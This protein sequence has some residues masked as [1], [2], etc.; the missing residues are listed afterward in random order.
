MKLKYLFLHN[1]ARISV[2]GYALFILV[3]AFLLMLPISVTGEGIGFVNALF[4][5]TS[6]ASVTGLN[7]V[8][9]GTVFTLFGQTVIMVFVQIGGLGIM[10]LST[11]LMMMAGI[12]PG[13]TSRAVVQ[14]TFNLE[15]M[16]DFKSILKDVI[17]FTFAIEGIGAALLLFY[18]L[19]QKSL[20]EAVYFSIFHSICAFCNA[21]FALFSNNFIN[22]QHSWG[23][24]IVICLLI[25]FGGIGF[26]VLSE[27]KRKVPINKRGFAR[28]S[29]HSK[30]VLSL[31]LI[32]IISGTL[33]ITIMEW[34]NTLSLF[35]LPDKFLAGFFQA[36]TARTAGFNTLPIGDMA[37]GALFLI[38]ILMFVGASPGS[39]AGGIK[40]TTV[41]CLF[42]LGLARLKGIERPTL[43][44]RSITQ[45][46]VGRAASVTMVSMLVVVSGTMVML[47][48]ETGSGGL[49]N[50]G[51]FIE[52]FFEVVSA[53]G[54]VG[55]STGI[56]GVLTAVGK[57]V[58]TAVMFIGRLGPLVVA[59]AVSRTSAPRYSYAE[60]NIMIG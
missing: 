1:P 53:F 35:S 6:A 16:I 21:G 54:T 12:K 60:E 4:T 18:F 31:T 47:I 44:K 46:S 34:D 37:N 33:L 27:I 3:G 23:F 20:P 11:V 36:V 8:D 43:F 28:L 56:T 32:L 26:I 58:I 15:G 2:I 57:L 50:R 5:A 25:I 13:I 52:L 40:T 39:C 59:M 49:L 7:V 10:T 48:A 22:Y 19:P 17:L 51:K 45:E 29:L 14:D 9:T 30:I 41:A 55:L 38:I 24:N 42:S